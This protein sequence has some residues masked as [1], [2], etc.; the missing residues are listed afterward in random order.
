MSKLW[1]AEE[2]AK[3]LDDLA[4][5][6]QRGA[7]TAGQGLLAAFNWGEDHGL[8]QGGGPRCYRPLAARNWT[9]ADRIA[10]LFLGLPEELRALY[11][12][13]P[14]FYAVVQ[15]AALRGA[16]QTEMLTEAVKHLGNSRAQLMQAYSEALQARPPVFTLPAERG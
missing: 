2:I 15:S 16:S 7:L 13:D 12:H 9:A 8:Q 6:V 14:L 10:A 3:R 4:Q 5:R 1:T 11:R